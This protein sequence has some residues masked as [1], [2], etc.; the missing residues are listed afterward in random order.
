M[1]SIGN[2]YEEK[3]CAYLENKG[4]VC[5]TRNYQ[6]RTGEI[7]L[8]MQDQDDIVFVEVRYRR[9][10]HFGDALESITPQK[11]RRIEKTA[12]HY[13][14]QTQQYEKKPI[15]FDVIAMND[16]TIEWLKAAW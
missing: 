7:D 8:I 1:R 5:I 12:M 10:S 13:L 6:S 9:E 14:L 11:Q 3:A 4:L 2:T 15:R 16:D